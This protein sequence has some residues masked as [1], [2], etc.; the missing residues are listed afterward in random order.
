MNKT[1]KTQDVTKDLFQQEDENAQP[2]LLS[3]VD[4]TGMN[5]QQK[6]KLKKKLKKLLDK[7][8]QKTDDN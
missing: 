6:K 4:T 3:N 5:K 1:V 2:T 7:G 8:G